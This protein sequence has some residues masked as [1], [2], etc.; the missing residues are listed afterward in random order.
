MSFANGTSGFFSATWNSGRRHLLTHIHG[1]NCCAIIDCEQQGTF[2]SPDHTEGVTRTVAE[3]AGSEAKHRTNGFFDESREFVDAVKVGDPTCPNPPSRSAYRQWRRGA[4]YSPT[5]LDRRA[6]ELGS[7]TASAIS[8]AANGG[9]ARDHSRD[10]LRQRPVSRASHAGFR[11]SGGSPGGRP[12]SRHGCCCMAA[13][14]GRSA[15]GSNCGMRAGMRPS[16]WISAAAVPIATGMSGRVPGRTIRPS[17]MSTLAG[18]TCG[19]IM[20]SPPRCALTLCWP[21]EP[22][23][24]AERIGATGISWG[25][26]LTCILAG[27]DPRLRFAVP[28]YGCGFLQDNSADEW[29]RI[30]ADMTPAKRREWPPALRSLAIPARSRSAHALRDRV[31]TISP[32]RSIVCG[33]ART[34]FRAPCATACACGCRTGHE[35]GWAPAEIG[36]FAD[37]ILGDAPGLPEFGD[38]SMVAGEVSCPASSERGIERAWLLHTVEDGPWQEREWQRT[39]AAV[40]DGTVRADV[41]AD[42][43]VWFLAAEED[44]DGGLRQH[45]PDPT[46]VVPRP[47]CI[48]PV[49]N[50]DVHRED[51]SEFPHGRHRRLRP[52]VP[53]CPPGTPS[54]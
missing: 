2:Y 47:Y 41:P 27:V 48:P 50:R 21:P 42:A 29:M 25:G 32:T 10:L 17:S 39:P 16:P 26:Y 51:R 15:S 38:V 40:S 31:P 22:G 4:G 18:T 5:P 46:R 11:L 3:A 34:W 30:F 28:V 8:L 53:G 52:G 37:S 24:D 12:G 54:R 14:G 1:Q 23:V 20:P 49:E 13:A 36:R 19:P 33:R 6:Y 45:A 7:R 43:T 44:G 35:A 9:P